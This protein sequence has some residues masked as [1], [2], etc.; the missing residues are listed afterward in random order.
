[1]DLLSGNIRKIYLHYFATVFIGACIPCVYGI[2]DSAVVGQYHG[3][4][5]TA[6]MSVVMPVFTIVY[7]LGFLVGIG[8][9]VLYSTKKG[10][11]PHDRLRPNE[12]F[13]AALAA[14]VILSFLVWILCWGFDRELLVF[15]GADEEL[16]A[17]ALRYMLPLKIAAPVFLF[18]Q[19]LGTFLRND[20]APGLATAA[21]T[22]GGVFNVFGDFFF[23]FGLD[24]GILGASIATC[25][26]G[27][28]NVLVLLSHFL[29]RK[30]TLT[31]VP[32][33]HFLLK[34]RAL[35][36]LG[37]PAFFTD[38][39]MGIVIVLFNRQIMHY[40]GTN[41]LSIFGVLVNIGIFVQCC[42]YSI[43][44]AAQPILSINYGARK[45]L[46]IRE[47]LRYATESSIVLGILWIAL[48]M[49]CPN[50]FIYIFM[51]PTEEVLA[52]APGIIRSYALAFLL[53]PFNVFSTFYFQALLKP[54][55][56]FAVSMSRG[57]VCCSIFILAL[58]AL[59]GADAIW[60]SIPIAE[61]ITLLFAAFMTVRYT[62]RLC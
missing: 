36:T 26:G 44:Q 52:M 18:A 10:K 55:A 54:T 17:L 6:A 1:M 41:A 38:F 46:R 60:F 28:L 57:F 3:P 37:F 62:R 40:L 13:T 31:I 59:F 2:V 21:V 4:A 61:A 51:A 53:I 11:F 23:V 30:N 5:G 32:V 12:F 35:L 19:F 58:P 45:G 20:D 39:A 8:G 24:L 9:C 25:V 50:A 33:K 49:A 7:S 43:G 27:L 56:A 14:A 47:T 15:F 16:L 34:M 22:V 48:A 29:S 42:G